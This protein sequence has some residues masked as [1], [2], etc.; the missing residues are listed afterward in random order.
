MFSSVLWL[1]F[2]CVLPILHIII[3]HECTLFVYGQW[4][5]RIKLLNISIWHI[6]ASKIVSHGL[7]SKLTRIFFIIYDI[8]IYVSTSMVKSDIIHD[9]N[10]HHPILIYPSLPT[11]VFTTIKLFI[12]IR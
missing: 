9:Q 8:M 12:C 11:E 3:K 6:H 5:I 10:R 4:S 1:F 7:Q 2:I